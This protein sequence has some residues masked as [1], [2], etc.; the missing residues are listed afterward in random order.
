MKIPDATALRLYLRS[1][2]GVHLH[3][4]DSIACEEANLVILDVPCV[5]KFGFSSSI[6]C[7]KPVATSTCVWIFSSSDPGVFFGSFYLPVNEDSHPPA[8]LNSA[9]DQAIEK[10]KTH[11]GFLAMKAA[12]MVEGASMKTRQVRSA[13]FTPMPGQAG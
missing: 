6:K 5:V 11:H 12:L 10:A 8:I 2:S 4:T 1:T 9:I 7:V 13:H 3:R